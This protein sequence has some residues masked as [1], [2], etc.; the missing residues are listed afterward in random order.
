MQHLLSARTQK[1]SGL[2]GGLR[3]EI[4]S[5]HSMPFGV[6]NSNGRAWLTGRVGRPGHGRLA[7][8][9]SRER[10]LRSSK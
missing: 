4:K 10:C 7:R 3:V 9:I 8:V 2:S 6:N 5:R 1:A